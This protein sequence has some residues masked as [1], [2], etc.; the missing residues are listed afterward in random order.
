[1]ATTAIVAEILVIGLQAVIWIVLLA[2]S[3]GG[4]PAARAGLKEW[5][6]LIT[7]FTLGFAYAFGIIIDRISDSLFTAGGASESWAEQRLAVLAR[8]DKVTDFLE[9]IRS[10]LRIARAS[11]LNF[12]LIT[13]FGALFL[14]VRSDATAG[15][16]VAATA[17]GIGITIAAG[18]VAARIRKTYDK[19]LKQAIELAP[20]SQDRA[21]EH[22]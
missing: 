1:M 17:S 19:R 9:Y 8:G 13:L 15:Q 4:V 3:I 22:K 21:H 18:K 20:R 16:I 5:V 7:A 10:R 11:T 6:P 12:A 14:C 2:M